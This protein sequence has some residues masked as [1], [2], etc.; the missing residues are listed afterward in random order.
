MLPPKLNMGKNIV[1]GEKITPR[2]FRKGSREIYAKIGE[3]VVEKDWLK[4]SR[5][6]A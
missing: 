4:K 6:R 1:D 5:G 3:L 2:G